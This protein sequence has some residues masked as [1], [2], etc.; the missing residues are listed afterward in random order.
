MTQLIHVDS[1][2][3]RIEVMYFGPVSV[4][5]RLDVVKA[6]ESRAGKLDLK[7]ILIDYT[8]SWLDESTP[9]DYEQVRQRIRGSSWLKGLKIALV[10]PAE[11]HPYPT[12]DISAEVGFTVRRFHTRAAALEWLSRKP[13]AAE[14][15]NRTP[16]ADGPRKPAP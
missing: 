13:G 7:G 15:A 2:A 14:A 5:D 8:Q 4:A 3:G 16:P 12:D 10:S 1:T 9:H 6:V 11:F